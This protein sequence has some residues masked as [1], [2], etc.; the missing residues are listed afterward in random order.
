MIRKLAQRPDLRFRRALLTGASVT[1]LLMGSLVAVEARSLGGGSGAASANAAAAAQAGAQQAAAAAAVQTSISMARANA[2]LAAMRARLQLDRAA[3]M[4]AS[5]AVPNGLTAGGLVVAPNAG[6]DPTLWQGANAPTSAPQGGRI[7]VEVKQTQPKAI[8]TWSSFNIGR[9]TDLYFN[10]TAGGSDVPNWIVMNRVIDPSLAP[11]RILGTIKAEGQVYAINRNGIVFGG[12]SQI[13]VST[14]VASSLEIALPGLSGASYL[15]DSPANVTARNARF[16]NGLLS[17]TGDLPVAFGEDFTTTSQR[18][19]AGE[20][21]APL[22]GVTIDAGAQIRIGNYGQAFLAGHNVV[23]RGTIEAPNGQ[24]V[25]AAGRGVVINKSALP[26]IRGYLLAVDRGGVVE[27]S[28]LVSTPLGNITMTGKTINQTGVLLATTGVEANGSIVMRAVEGM[29]NRQAF[30]EVVP[31]APE[32]GY[33]GSPNAN[34]RRGTVTF[35]PGSVTAITPDDSGQKAVGTIGYRQSMMDVAGYK[36]LALDESTLYLPSGRIGL[37]TLPEAATTGLDSR[38]YIGQGARIDVSGLRDVSV[39]ME[40]NAIQAELRAAELSINPVLRDSALRGRKIT[41]DARFG[42]RIADVAGYYDLIARDIGQFMTTGGTIAL[43][44]KE[45]IA[46]DGSTIDLSGGSVRYGDG[47]IKSTILMDQTG[48]RVRIEDAVPGV[49]YIE[50]ERGF[51]VMRPRWGMTEIHTSVFD[52][53][54][55]S[56]FVRGYV[57]GRSA[58]RLELDVSRDAAT[59]GAQ[60]RDAFRI[61]D[62]EMLTGLVVGPNQ[63][64]APTG[65]GMADVSKVWQEMP[66]RASLLFGGI[67]SFAGSDPTYL[68][69]D[70]TIADVGPRLASGFKFDTALDYANAYRHI[71]PAHWF[72]GSGF[73]NVTLRS[74]YTSQGAADPDTGVI[75]GPGPYPTAGHLVIGAGVTV[76]LGLFGAFNFFGRQADIAGTVRAPGGSVSIQTVQAPSTN[77]GSSTEN[78]AQLPDSERPGTLLRST[79]VIDVAGLWLNEY[80]SGERS[81]R[82]IDGGKVRIVSYNLVAY[83]GSLIDVSGGGHLD[84]SGSRITAGNGGSIVIDTSARYTYASPAAD[85]EPSNGRLVL[86]GTLRGY[87]LGRGGTLSIDTGE[88]IVI[89]NHAVTPNDILAAGQRAPRDLRLATSVIV[90]AGAR[91]PVAGFYVATRAEA[92]RALPVAVTVTGVSSA[93]PLSIAADWTVPAGVT[94]RSVANTQYRAGAVVPAGTQLMTWTGTLPANYVVPANAFPH[95][96]A[97]A[98]K[99]ITHPAGIA[100]RDVTIAASTLIPT[101]AIFDQQVQFVTTRAIDADLFTRG[102]FSGFAISGARGVTVAAGTVIAPSVETLQLGDALLVATGTKLP[103]VAGRVVLPGELRSAMTLSLS[104]MPVDI[105]TGV[106]VNR[107]E[108]V[109]GTG[110]L[111]AG[112]VRYPGVLNIETGATIRMEPGSLVRLASLNNLFVDGTAATPGGTIQVLSPVVRLGAHARLAAPGYVDVVRDGRQMQRR[113]AAGGTI[114]IAGGRSSLASAPWASA[115]TMLMD[116]GAVLD[117]SGIRDIADLAGTGSNPVMSR[118]PHTPTMIDGNAGAISIYA[119]RGVL[120]GQF[121]LAPGGEAGKGGT[122]EIRTTIA[123]TS[124][125]PGVIVRQDMLPGFGPVLRNS[126]VPSLPGLIVVADRINESD[127]DD[128]VLGT[129]T[130][131]DRTNLGIRFDGDVTLNARRSMSLVTHLLGTIT[132]RPARV[133]LGASYV[134]LGSGATST[135]APLVAATVLNGDLTVRADLID[136]ATRVYLGCGLGGCA[137]VGGFDTARFIATGDIRLHGSE[138]NDPNQPAGLFSAGALAFNAAQTYVTARAGVVRQSSDPGFLV[139]SNRSVTFTGNGGAAPVPYSFGERL[140]VRAPSIV[141][142]GVLRAPQGEIRLEASQS[143]TLAPGSLTSAS[144]EGLVVPYGVIEPTL[145]FG[146]YRN[147]GDAPVKAVRLDGPNV[148]VQAGAVIDVS[149]GGDLLAWRFVPGNGGRTDILAYDANTFRF[150]IVPGMSTTPLPRQPY[151]ASGVPGNNR[152]NIN[153]LQD[154]RLKVGDR[155][156]LDGVLGLAPGYYTLLPSAYALLPGGRLVEPIGGSYRSAQ[157]PLVRPDGAVIA[158]GYYAVAGTPIHDQGYTRFLVMDQATFGQYTETKAYSFNAVAEDLAAAA[159]AAVRTPFDAGTVILAATQ[160][161]SLNGSGRF[162]APAGGLQGNLDIAAARLAVVGDGATAPA[163]FLRL[164][165]RAVSAFGAGSLLIGGT[166]TSTAAGTSVK[167]IATDVIV[168]TAASPLSGPEIILGATTSL[169]IAD[170]AVITATGEPVNDRSDLLLTGDSALLRLSTGSRIGV[171]RTGTAGVAGE[172]TIGR[173]AMLTAAGSMLLDASRTLAIAPD[174]I[175]AARQ[176]DLASRRINIGHVPAGETGTTLGLDTVARLASASDLLLRGQE[177][178]H[179]YGDIVLGGRTPSGD[180]TLGRLTLDTGL[181]QGHA[182]GGVTTTIAVGE[183]TLMNSAAPTAA[184]ANA[185]A[186]TLA[187][188]VDTL[189]LSGAVRIGGYALLQ[190]TMGMLQAAGSGTLE[191]AGDATLATGVATAGSGVD[192]TLK[193]GGHLAL[194]QSARAFARPT[195]MGGRL[196]VDAAGTVLLA[197]KVILPSGVFEATAGD[198]VV[199]APWALIDVAGQA[200][201]MRDVVKYAPGGMIRLTA[202]NVLD[203]SQGTVLDVSAPAGRGDAGTI[204]LKA[205]DA[206]NI[207]ATL[208]GQAQPDSRGGDFTLDAARIDS[209]STLNTALNRGGF[210]HAR[211]LRLRQQGISLGAGETIIAHDVSLRSD[212]GVVDIVGTIDAAGTAGSPDGG[213]VRLTGGTGVTLQAT[214]LIDGQARA[215]EPGGFDPASGKVEINALDGRIDIAPGAVI[216]VSGG[217]RSGGTIVI[218]ARR[219]G[220]DIAIDRL[221]GT[222]IGARLREIDGVEVYNSSSVDAAIVNTMLNDAAA[223]LGNAGTIQARLGRPDFEVRPGMLMASAGDLAVNAEID[224]AGLGGAGYL[225]LTAGGNI[226]VNATISDGFANASRTAALLAGRSFTYGLDS[227]GDIALA[228]NAMIRTGTGDI[229]IAAGRD[230]KLV[231]QN[232]VIYSAGRKTVTEAGFNPALLGTARVGDFATEGGNIRVSA[233][234]DITAPLT[235]QTSSAWLF[236]YGDSEWNGNASTSK[237][238]QQ[239]SWSVV[240]KNFEQGVGALGGGNVKVNAGR[241]IKDL[242]VAIPTTG[243]MTTSIGTVADASQLYVRGGGDLDLLA[244]RDVLGGLFVLGKGEAEVMAGRNLAASADTAKLRSALV[245]STF[246]DGSVNA[247]FG[248][249][250]ATARVTALSTA[251]IHAAFDPM[252]QSQITENLTGTPALT[253]SGFYGYSARTAL[254]VTAV[255]G[256][257]SYRNDPWASVDMS[258]GYAYAVNASAAIEGGTAPRPVLLELLGRAP[259]T[260]KFASLESSVLMTPRFSSALKIASAPRGTLELLA[261]QDVRIGYTAP[262]T[263]IVMEDVAAAYDRGPLVAFSTTRGAAGTDRTEYANTRPIFGPSAANNMLRGFTLLHAGDRD[264]ARIYA[265]DGSVCNVAISIACSATATGLAQFY[266]TL[267][268]AAAFYAGRDILSPKLSLQHNQ[269]D[270]WSSVIAG[271]DVRNPAIAAAGPGTL[272]IEAGQSIDFGSGN[273]GAA[274]TSAGGGGT[275]NLALPRDVAANIMM[276]AG[277]ANATDYDRFADTYLDPANSRGVVRTYLA[278]LADYMRGMGVTGLSGADLVVAFKA[279][280]SAHREAFLL[281]V[282]FTE[283]KETGIDYNN[284]AGARYQNYD[285]GYQAVATLFPVSSNKAA[286]GNILLNS[287]PVETMVQADITIVAPYGRVEIGTAFP[288]ENY[289]PNSGGAVTRRGGDVRIMA[290]QNIDLFTS[291][292]FTLQGGDITMWTSNGDITAGSGAKTSV[293]QVPLSYTMSNDGVID[294]NVFGLQTGAGIGVLDSVGAA[295]GSMGVTPTRR[296]SRIDLLAFRGEVNAGDAGIRVLGD[297]NIGALR[298]VGLNNIQVIGGTATGIPQ[299]TTLTVVPLTADTTAAQA[300][301]SAKDAMQASAPNQGPSVIIVEVLG[302]GG[303]DAMPSETEP[304]RRE[305]RAYDVDSRFQIVGAGKLNAI[306]ETL[307]TEAEKRAL[308]QQAGQ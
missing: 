172:L 223:W 114:L 132:S 45:I 86:D 191:F 24:V 98:A 167:V 212:A 179:L 277:A 62:G 307:L 152:S 93:T 226:A 13:N 302:Y 95:G 215:A 23:N 16:L 92:G 149:G 88:E 97:I 2:S 123:G 44:G 273:N 185:G 126:A 10:Q 136:I 281:K 249:M 274:V 285:R 31:P 80:L 195:A 111:S 243:H 87:A 244:G 220:N 148:N 169:T 201:A 133:Q 141:Q 1:A 256:A 293:F 289:S 159:G 91:L 130:Y 242:A 221:A 129:A 40:Q 143:L 284:S 154:P 231:A 193:V 124:G 57:E 115:V 197:S 236:R 15:S 198:S 305:R 175:F 144:L 106:A 238:I 208:R 119:T 253:G 308:M 28:G 43:R 211:D 51:V 222:F 207:A 251:T 180:A 153:V 234:R 282:Y 110:L 21:F 157:A 170:N 230:L 19:L 142:G 291:R 46:R 17:F 189:L 275:G 101:G 255:G 71:L 206:A 109:D 20:V 146:D 14:L 26:D 3:A 33:I 127:L 18:S 139:S 162:G 276:R 296:K 269:A 105:D 156:W 59:A 135:T 279:L 173:H 38:V 35:G 184:A 166:R 237:V 34:Q 22:D 99:T 301:S 150:A 42:V 270:A 287:K 83:K 225:G 103:E 50:S 245:S 181:L 36:I 267:P 7:Q 37:W 216:N 228:A 205:G 74:G 52:R 213:S 90:P 120:G 233:G 32:S 299:A 190:G 250:D 288:P 283:L 11:S 134:S 261:Q 210:N 70:I 303:E 12:S 63:L 304:R 116:P 137:G 188:D 177:S 168:D 122:L 53:G 81:P 240:Y 79:G 194:T 25:F 60:A 117:V 147:P 72:D 73:G 164:D 138:A 264:N 203:L 9:E 54:Q 75:S 227:G 100:T 89:S 278:E 272:L 219:S 199:V 48:R 145:V 183:L 96:I 178:I 235:Q 165:A 49:T 192:Y 39:A 118:A 182:D 27:N 229:T 155:V 4:A 217:S 176:L 30:T 300:A 104:T 306:G 232:S 58:G 41:F 271:R 56:G 204:A 186:G 209:F 163:G 55:L 85:L 298:V 252:L 202:A 239:T 286:V 107:V 266:L 161:L 68:G 6:A 84:S 241:D 187:L 294:L 76:D 280:P 200:L 297:I 140:T 258:R 292:V 214:A 218:R 263:A 82:A 262:S 131:A 113:V 61:F 248:L 102:G 121:E 64:A 67:L 268:K 5:G 171:T 174:S 8:L 65:A 112:S 290:D 295:K 224:L 108:V 29:P 196:A 254:D 246:A 247:M 66:A 257:V 47:Y 125:D 259:D 69:G 160:S 260:L 94:V 158:T 78:W 128:L 77:A 265:L 151:A